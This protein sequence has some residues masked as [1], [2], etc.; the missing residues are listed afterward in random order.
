MN[1]TIKRPY[2]TFDS[3]WK[4]FVILLLAVIAYQLSELNGNRG[5][6]VSGG[7]IGIDTSY[8]G[9]IPVAVTRSEPLLVRPTSDAR[10]MVTSEHPLV[11][12]LDR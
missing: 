12:H 11:V 9:A 10:F 3:I 4:L 8:S 6:Y 1:E 2:I 5:V 7:F